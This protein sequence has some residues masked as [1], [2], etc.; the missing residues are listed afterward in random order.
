MDR[1]GLHG[2]ESEALNA[3]SDTFCKS[4]TSLRFTYSPVCTDTPGLAVPIPSASAS[5]ATTKALKVEQA[6]P[7]KDITIAGLKI[8]NYR[9]IYGF[10][11]LAF[12]LSY[13]KFLIRLAELNPTTLNRPAA[14][15]V[16]QTLTC[17]KYK[18]WNPDPKQYSAQKKRRLL[19]DAHSQVCCS[20]SWN[21][22]C[23]WTVC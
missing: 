9:Y 23:W 15:K 6:L 3:L 18:E 21:T 11:G 12:G 2:E 13:K 20:R 7:K 17:E 4:K 10:Y 14:E 22:E 1:P 16:W 8:P 19:R 5:E